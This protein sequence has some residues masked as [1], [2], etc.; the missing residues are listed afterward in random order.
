[1]SFCLPQDG[2][3]VCVRVTGREHLSEGRGG[4]RLISPRR[5]RDSGRWRRTCRPPPGWPCWLACRRRGPTWC[6]PGWR[7]GWSAWRC[8][9]RCAAGWQ[10]TWASAVAPRGRRGRPSA[11][12]RRGTGHRCP[13]GCGCCGA[14]STC[15][16]QQKHVK[17]GGS[18]DAT[19]P[20]HLW[21]WYYTFLG[22][23]VCVCVCV[24]FNFLSFIEL[25]TSKTILSLPSLEGHWPFLT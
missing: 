15:G 2:V 9:P 16:G 3:C 8:G 25:E 4:G 20:L 11:G 22:L 7:A 19:N 23:S 18:T 17:R 24:C 5:C 13:P 1:M 10:C 12:A 14:G 21:T 6:P